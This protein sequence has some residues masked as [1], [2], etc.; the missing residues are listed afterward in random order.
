MIGSNGLLLRELVRQ[1]ILMAARDGCGAT[2]R[3]AVLG[4]AVAMEK[5]SAV[6][7][8]EWDLPK[9]GPSTVLLRKEAG[10]ILWKAPA[11]TGGDAKD[12]VKLAG[13]MASQAGGPLV[14]ALEKAGLK[15]V[16]RK[17]GAVE[18]I[19]REV[20]QALDRMTASSQFA[21]VRGLHDRLRSRGESP[22]L[23]GALARGYALLGVLT[24]HHW[25]PAHKAYKARALLY[26]NRAA[27]ADAKAPDG[28]RSLAFAEALVGRQEDALAHL[29]EA[30]R[31]GG[32]G[33]KPAWVE[34]VRLFCGDEDDKL[35]RGE[36]ADDP[37]A[38][39]LSLVCIE[40]SSGMFEDHADLARAQVLMAT[41][42][43]LQREP[44]CF[45]ALD[46]TCRFSGVTLLH[47]A[48][49][50]GPQLLART[51]A[52]SL[53][54]VPGIPADLGDD[55]LKALGGAAASRDRGEPSLA[56]LASIVRETRFAQ[57]WQ[58][59]DFVLFKLS[60]PGMDGP[61]RDRQFFGD[62]PLLPFLD[63]YTRGFRTPE[64]LALA[65]ELEGA[66][67]EYSAIPLINRVS[68]VDADLGQRLFIRAMSHADEVSR[69]L[70]EAIR[71]GPIEWAL[72]LVPR[73]QAVRPNS[74][75]ARI[76]R[77]A[78][79]KNIDTDLLVEWEKDPACGPG[80]LGVM[81]KRYASAKR[82]ADAERCLERAIAASPDR[83]MY[84]AL[85]EV[86][87][88]QGMTDKWRTTLEGFLLQED[89][90]LEHAQVRNEIARD[91][92]SR[93][94]Y[95]E[96]LPYA[97]AAAQTW[98]AWA[99]YTASDCRENLGDWREAERWVR[100]VSGR[101]DDQFD[102]W[103]WWCKRT[104]HG[105]AEAALALAKPR[106]AEHAREIADV[107]RAFS[108]GNVLLAAGEPRL[109]FELA[110]RLNAQKY[111]QDLTLR[112]ADL[113]D[114]FGE[115]GAR[116]RAIAQFLDDKDAAGYATTKALRVL[117]EWLAKPDANQ[118]PPDLARLDAII[119][120]MPKG[121][122]NLAYIVGRLLLNHGYKDLGTSYLAVAAQK[123]LT[124]TQAIFQVLAR[125]ALRDAGLDPDKVTPRPL[126]PPGGR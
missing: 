86:Y 29:V 67:I 123:D 87:K 124:I 108:F 113:A 126:K 93:Q 96:A 39:L 100:A 92:M 35:I 8:V 98:A 38:R 42:E 30:D 114:Q 118:V 63:A 51:L 22:E 43:L 91:Y 79:E 59:A 65:K 48:T 34:W 117:R 58:R 105:D 70:A 102:A 55:P 41:N 24:E 84:H 12:P 3:D 16:A 47:V 23:L 101:Y 2:T 74:P 11:L 54:A 64:F 90:A 37:L 103:F 14:A 50:V 104:E 31:R 82:W 69:D 49:A 83:W 75:I 85:A 57:A 77:A 13:A 19:P 44:E 46:S 62:H 6:L 21:A 7:V 32:A 99:M 36:G 10:E 110:K 25:H 18:P 5:P 72:P 26:G 17:P 97:E 122:G 61:I 40:G 81:G 27:A 119:A 121:G 15:R 120:S 112:I 20:A 71:F 66:D 111:D 1:S 60:A 106:F 53:A 116:D 9:A 125:R 33:R 73:L 107:R 28:L 45:R 95:K 68:R 56:A 109:A 94:Q 88:A 52:G 76:V 80:L 89:F 115:S 4:D 78:L